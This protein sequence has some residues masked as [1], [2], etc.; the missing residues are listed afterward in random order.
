MQNLVFSCLPWFE[1]AAPNS[2]W[3]IPI[4]FKDVTNYYADDRLD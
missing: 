2:A 3:Q 4:C 1:A